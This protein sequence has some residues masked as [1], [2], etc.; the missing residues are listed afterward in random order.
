M[1]QI[2]V[3]IIFSIKYF[4]IKVWTLI[5]LRHN[6]I[7]HLT[8]Y[9]IVWRLCIE[10]PKYLWLTFCDTYLIAVIWNQIYNILKYAC[11]SQNKPQKFK[12]IEIISSMFSDHS[13]IKLDISTP[14]NLG[15]W[16]ICGN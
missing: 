9:R 11:M 14:G 2:M 7:A 16:Q 5:F 12:E 13:E 10:K 8:D 3:N 4:T 1:A 6:V 15:N